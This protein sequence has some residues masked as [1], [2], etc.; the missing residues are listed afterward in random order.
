MGLII[1]VFHEHYLKL[2][3]QNT[4]KKKINEIFYDQFIYF[5]GEKCQCMGVEWKGMIRFRE[6]GLLIH[7]CSR[8]SGSMEKN[9]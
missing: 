7:G 2:V 8:E 6:C 9:L 1:N 4:L 5:L 3:F